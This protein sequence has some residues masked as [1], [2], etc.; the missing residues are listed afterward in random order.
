HLRRI[1]Q[2]R[3]LA[4]DD[5]ADGPPG[6]HGQPR[7]VLHQVAQGW[8]AIRSSTSMLADESDGEDGVRRPEELSM[9]K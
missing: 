2:R 6:I 7:Q 8:G 1:V 3:L 9:A 5:R 4:D